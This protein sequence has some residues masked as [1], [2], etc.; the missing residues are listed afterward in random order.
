LAVPWEHGHTLIFLPEVTRMNQLP[1]R[2]DLKPEKA[3]QV[4]ALV[5]VSLNV[6]FSVIHQISQER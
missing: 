2:E 5:I 4:L 1:L 6:T 3:A